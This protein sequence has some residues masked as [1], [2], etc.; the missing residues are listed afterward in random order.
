MFKNFYILKAFMDK[1][2][3]KSL[4][5][6][7]ASNKGKHFLPRLLAIIILPGVLIGF[8]GMR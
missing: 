1:S 6:L 4:A 5:T 2:V 7:K 3:E 8:Y